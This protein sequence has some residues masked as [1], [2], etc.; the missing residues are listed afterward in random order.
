MLEDSGDTIAP[1]PR[2]RSAAHTGLLPPQPAFTR[3]E[4]TDADVDADADADADSHA[5]GHA[6]QLDPDS[7]C[8]DP[9]KADA[10]DADADTN[11][12]DAD[13]AG[14]DNATE[15]DRVD[16]ANADEAIEADTDE[17]H[18]DA[19]AD[20][21]DANVDEVDANVGEANETPANVDEANADPEGAEDAD[22]NGADV[23]EDNAEDNDT[24]ATA[25]ATAVDHEDTAAPDHVHHHRTPSPKPQGASRTEGGILRGRAKGNVFNF[26]DAD[27]D[28]VPQAPR[29]KVVGRVLVYEHGGAGAEPR[30]SMKQEVTSSLESVL[31]QLGDMHSP[32]RSKSSISTVIILQLTTLSENNPRIFVREEGY[33]EAYGRF[34]NA[35]KTITPL[36]WEENDNGRLVLSI[37]M[38]CPV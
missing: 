22:E 17:A 3:P 2:R 36:N 28:P 7:E 12:A 4:E 32:V 23:E 20:E 8:D 35:I 21:A 16:E 26:G 27:E 33:W 37:L 24:A 5:D 25:V 10:D 9:E 29:A 13:D 6:D 18:A 31:V 19:N 11:D 14:A 15:A 30:F 1:P 34:E 38:V